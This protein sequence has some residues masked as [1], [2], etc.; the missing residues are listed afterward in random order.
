METSTLNQLIETVGIVIIVLMTIYAYSK[1]VKWKYSVKGEIALLKDIIFF[2][3]VIEKY[4]TYMTENELD[5]NYKKFRKEVSHQI[6]WQPSQK[7]E[8]AIIKR[9]LDQLAHHDDTIDTFTSKITL[10]K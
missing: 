10:T 7:S 6:D 2:R 1:A 5:M 8:P 3:G 9:R 4:K